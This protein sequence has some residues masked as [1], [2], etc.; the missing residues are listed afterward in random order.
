MA[1][2]DDAP[3]DVLP[4]ARVLRE[5]GQYRYDPAQV[6]SDFI[7]YA[8]ACFL[9]T[10]D[11]SVAEQLR[12]TYGK[13]YPK[14]QQMFAAWITI[15]HQQF[16]RNKAWFDALG[17]L[18]EYLGHN[19]KKSILGQFFTPPDLCDMMT[20]LNSP[21]EK[22]T[23]RRVNDPACGSGRTLLS[24]NAAHPG[25][26]LF[27]EDKD[28]ICAKITAI[29]FAVHGVQGQVTCMDSLSQEDWRLCYQVNR[30]HRFGLPP[31]PHL[32]SISRNQSWLWR[33]QIS[34]NGG[35]PTMERPDAPV[36]DVVAEAKPK[37]NKNGQLLIF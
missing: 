9:T 19:S 5:F 29:N 15:L 7:D 21:A 33:E 11:R 27:A 28:Q 13:E 31:I 35:E 2:L 32:E 12:Q 23:S 37:M 8:V 6:F 25:N 10:G 16:N 24:F 34:D 17:M 36:T 22:L 1:Y 14:F 26:Y 20:A 18:Y 3:K 30:Y 4:I